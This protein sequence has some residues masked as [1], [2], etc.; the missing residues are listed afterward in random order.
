MLAS[1]SSHRYLLSV[2]S[3]AHEQSMQLLKDEMMLHINQLRLQEGGG[4]GEGAGGGKGE[5]RRSGEEHSSFD[6]GWA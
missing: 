2:K 1:R 3:P 5:Y 4:P 6:C